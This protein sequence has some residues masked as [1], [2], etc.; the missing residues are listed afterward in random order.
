MGIC[1]G[2]SVLADLGRATRLD[3]ARRSAQACEVRAEL[4]TIAEELAARGEISLDDLGD[5]IGARA[6]TPEEIDAMM[7]LIE[8]R[9]TRILAPEGGGGEQRLGAVLAAA[10]ALAAELGR[11]PT[12]AE[13]AERSGLSESAVRVALRLAQ[14]IAR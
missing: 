7:Q 4:R 6:V 14:V 13:I 9:G 8:S 10:R 5:A 12:V 11:K 1:L 2:A 3:D